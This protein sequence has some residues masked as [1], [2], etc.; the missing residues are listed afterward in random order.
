[1]A[2]PKRSI[3]DIIPPARSKPI[4]AAHHAEE[5]VHEHP[6]LPLKPKRERRSSGMLG[7]LGVAFGVLI[8]VGIAFGVVSTVFHRAEVAITPY[9]FSVTAADTYEAARDGENLTFAEI[10]FEETGT[11]SVPS[12]GS[13][14]V[15]ERASGK[16]T[17]YNEYSTQ[18]QRLI[19]NTRFESENGLIYRVKSP[20]TVP[21]YTTSDGK[22]VPGSIEVTVYADE[23]GESYNAAPTSFTIPGLKGSPQFDSMYARNSESLVG[24]FI[25]EQAVVDQDVRDNA[26][27]ELKSE[28]DRT[29][30]AGLVGRVSD[31]QLMA[32]ES[33]TVDFVEEPDRATDS[34]AEVSVRAVA[35]APVFDEAQVAGLIAA[36]GGVVFDTPLRINN[37]HE[38][39]LQV[40]DDEENS[41]KNLAISGN[42]QLIAVFDTDQFIRDISGKDQGSIGAI[43]ARYPGIQD[44]NLSVYPF[45]RRTLPEDP[46]RF[47]VR[48]D[49]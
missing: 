34:G 16:I 49:E 44:I 41:A 37:L 10:S 21:G 43:L 15:E 8:I 1:M 40:Q 42:V 38:V 47:S 22:K 30:R 23:P 13:T 17:I 33:V 46:A 2:D 12:T 14:H 29:V 27:L 4:R 25:G 39:A 35:K 32:P 24:G 48:V 6:K 11:K 18:S 26:V 5:E 36:D 3:Q 7:L 9:A 20:V 19:T 45:W 31:G 28:L